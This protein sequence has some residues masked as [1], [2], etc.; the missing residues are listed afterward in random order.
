MFYYK[1]DI[2]NIGQVI[3]VKKLV[4]TWILGS[5]IVTSLCGCGKMKA[6]VEVKDNLEY[7][8]Y[9]KINLSD[10]I[11]INDGFISE[12]KEILLDKVGENKITIDYQ[13]YKKHKGSI[14]VN[15]KAYDK[16]VPFLSMSSNVYKVVNSDFDLCSSAFYADNYDRDLECFINGEYD[17]NKIGNYNLELVVRD[18]SGNESSQDFNLH[19]I[20]KFNSNNNTVAPEGYD[21][22]EAV[23]NYK[24][25]KTLLGI[26]V[27]SFQGEI[28]W[29]KVKEAGV[30]FAIIRLG[31]GYTVNMELVLDKYF[32]ENLKGAKENDIKIGVYFYSY[33]NEIEE[34]EKQAQFIV[35]NLNG[36][37]LD[38]GVTFDWENWNNFKDYHVNLYDLDN[39][40]NSFKK[41]LEDNGYK[42]MLYGSKFYLK[43]IWKTEDKDIWLAHYTNKTNYDKDYVMWQFSDKGIVEGINSFVDLD[44]LYK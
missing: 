10:L 44:V 5:L 6:T 25:D 1:Y 27:S 31:F 35:D 34:V 7:P 17:K 22:K 43:N 20:E 12:D 9:S 32:Q 2:Y 11:N 26:D 40:Y 24:N 13:D 23:S 15:V 38:L 19:M 42:T 29:E 30:E 14:E 4:R 3:E 39:M 18:Q 8:V 37:D 33:A 16:E 21:F 36:E 41:V 28:D